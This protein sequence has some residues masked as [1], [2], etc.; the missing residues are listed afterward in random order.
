[1]VYQT[2]SV[3]IQINTKQCVYYIVCFIIYNTLFTIGVCSLVKLIANDELCIETLIII[4]FQ[5]Q[6]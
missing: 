1:M 6:C 2:V 4:Y 3:W 5:Y